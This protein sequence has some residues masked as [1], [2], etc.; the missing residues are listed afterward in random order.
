MV[1]FLLIFSAAVGFAVT[2]LLTPYFMR[3]LWNIGIVGIDQQKAGKPRIPTSGGI[4]V[5]FSFFLSMMLFVAL[6]S[7]VFHYWLAI[8]DL[9][10]AGLSTLTIALVGFF[11]D[12]YIRRKAGVNASGA[13]EY[14]VGLAQW[15]KPLLTLIAAIPLMAV[16]VGTTTITLP[17]IGSLN[18]G[19][20]YPLLLVPIAVVCVSNASNMLAG[21]NGVEAGMMSVASLGIAYWS[22]AHGNYEGAAIALLGSASL[23]AFFLF[24][25][26]FPAKMLPGDS[27]TYFAGAMYASAVIAGNVEKLGLY[28]FFPWILEALLKLRGMFKVRSYGDLR[29]DGTLA[30]PYGRIYS[31]THV[32]MKANDRLKLGWGEREMAYALIGFEALVVLVAIAGAGA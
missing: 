10:A 19:I 17:I 6:N 15:Q 24:F 1:L 25:N 20:L 27:L 12:L 11:D 3:Y 23:A 21:L 16:N 9:L 8:E 32:V 30:P 5:A 31:L 14:R 7:F 18:I 29:K 2:F 26:R 4:P 13:V 28:M 22:F